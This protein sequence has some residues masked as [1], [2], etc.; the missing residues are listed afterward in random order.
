VNFFEFSNLEFY[1]I[2]VME[3]PVEEKKR[4]FV[5]SFAG[6]SFFRHAA[7]SVISANGS[8]IGTNL[9][10]PDPPEDFLRCRDGTGFAGAGALSSTIGFDCWPL[11]VPFVG[12]R[13]RLNCSGIT[14]FK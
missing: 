3:I 9:M 12:D 13:G 1:K 2:F 14:F 10:R 7:A 11:S 5:P 8:R 4:H 6:I